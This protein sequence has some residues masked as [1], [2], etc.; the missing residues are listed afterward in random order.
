LPIGRSIRIGKLL[1]R[2]SGHPRGPAGATEAIGRDPRNRRP[3][4]PFS[5]VTR[6]AS[7]S[8]VAR[9]AGGVQWPVRAAGRHAPGAGL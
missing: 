3:V 5:R 4:W 9:S 7:G 1:P 8:S 6:S 2:A